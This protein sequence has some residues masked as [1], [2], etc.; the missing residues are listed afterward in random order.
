MCGL[1]F[2]LEFILLCYTVL[3]LFGDK[4]GKNTKSCFLGDRSLGDQP[5]FLLCFTDDIQHYK[6]N[7]RSRPGKR[8]AGWIRGVP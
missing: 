5:H 7:G 4:Y 3:I 1:E 6:F 8:F 2:F